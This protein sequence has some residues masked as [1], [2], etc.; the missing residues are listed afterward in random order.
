V[1]RIKDRVGSLDLVKIIPEK[2]EVGVD[3]KSK[4]VTFSVGTPKSITYDG[5]ELLTG[6]R[7]KPLKEAFLS[8]N[9]FEG[10]GVAN[11]KYHGGPDRAVCVYPNEHYDMWEKEFSVTLSRPA[12]GENITV[13]NMTEENVCIGDIY[14]MGETVIQISQGR[15]PCQTISKSNNVTVFLDR[16]IETGYTGYFCRVLQEGVVT[17]DSEISLLER[18]PQGVTV[19]YAN[20]IFFH[21]QGNREG[22]EKILAVKELAPVWQG[23]LQRRLK[24]LATKKNKAQ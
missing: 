19:L 13:S 8:K 15:V 23:L 5:K 16:I 22:I 14:Q 2:V 10:D 17:K 1:I 12:F 21:D 4:L 9:A 11:T 6:I 24:K 20:Q 3:S 7:K 18:H